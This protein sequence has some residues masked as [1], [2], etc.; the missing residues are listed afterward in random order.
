MALPSY[1]PRR[2]TALVLC[3][4]GTAGAYHAGVLRALTEAGVKIDV[5]AAQGAGTV[6]ALTGAVDAGSAFWGDDG[7]WT[8]S[9]LPAYRWRRSLRLGAAGLAVA[10]VL[11]LSPLVVL[12]GAAVVYLLGVVTSLAGFP[13][14]AMRLTELYSQTMAALFDPP[15][16][17]TTMPRLVVLAL[18]LVMGTLGVAAWQAR[19]SRRTRRRTQGAI[20]W[21]LLG[22]PLDPAEPE[23]LARRV[24]Q[25]LTQASARAGGTPRELGVRYAE[26]LAENFGQPGFRE[27]LLAVHDVDSRRDVVVGAVA[28]AWQAAFASR[29]VGAGPREAE[30]IEVAAGGDGERGLLADAL[31]A[32]LRV[33]VASAPLEVE[34]PA[35]GY[36]RGE[37]HRWCDRPELVTRLVDELA[38]IGVEQ[39]VLVTPAPPATLPHDLR[40]RAGDLRD[41][42]GEGL[43]S[44][45]T[46]AFQEAWSAAASRFSGVFAIRPDHNPIGPFA[47]GGAY[48]ES[49]DRMRSLSEL[50]R[51]GHADAY[52]QFIEPV[53]AAGEEV[54]GL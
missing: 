50:V 37:V 43:R 54:A 16:L 33:P 12:V 5:I 3:G 32:S 45:E 13:D 15:L 28:P 14:T 18:L 36:W 30:A 35:N 6:G 48:D 53:V 9:T 44:I 47:F 7:P 20:W 22:Q 31:L 27:V 41:R 1:A 24:L 2:R 10:G 51:Q 26:L 49:S 46:A 11:V 34:L 29:R 40:S 21:H 39:L 23:G 8:A 25:G 19:R 17:P 4:T 38:R 52:T 42:M